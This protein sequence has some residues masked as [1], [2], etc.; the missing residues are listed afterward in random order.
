[1]TYVELDIMNSELGFPPLFPTK[2]LYHIHTYI[3]PE[4]IHD[5]YKPKIWNEMMLHVH[6]KINDIKQRVYMCYMK[7]LI[8]STKVMKEIINWSEKCYSKFVFIALQ[9]IWLSQL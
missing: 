1:M 8:T 4:H 3:W 5:L 2:T 6:M 7:K 9:V